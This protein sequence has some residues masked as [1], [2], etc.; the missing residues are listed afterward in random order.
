[1]AEYADWPEFLDDFPR[2]LAVKQS[3][4]SITARLS[5]D[6]DLKCFNGHFPSEP[7]LPGIIQTHWAV[8]IA[9][10]AFDFSLQPQRIKRLKFKQ[11]VVPPQQLDLVLSR[12]KHDEVQFAFTSTIGKHSEGRLVFIN[13]T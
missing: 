13:A 4:D 11:V 10:A 5:V 12:E 9:R 1:M 8:Q 2:I 3:P 6:P 7:V